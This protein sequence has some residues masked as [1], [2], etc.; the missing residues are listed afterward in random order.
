MRRGRA[1]VTDG[2]GV[3]VIVVNFNSTGLTPRSIESAAADLGPRAWRAIVVDNASSD[4]A[5]GALAT[6]PSTTVVR[7]ATNAGFG[8]AVNQAAAASTAP[9]L[10]ILNPDC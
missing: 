2:P 4:D 9:L 8:V 1:P 7:N 3:D 6:L 10:W 5:P